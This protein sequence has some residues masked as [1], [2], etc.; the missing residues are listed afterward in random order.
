M[1]PTAVSQVIEQIMNTVF[2]LGFAAVFIK[3]SVELGC[4][5]A[6]IGTTLGAVASAVYLMIVYV[7]T[8]HVK[9][10]NINEQVS[11]RRYTNRQ[12]L[13]KILKY[14]IPIT[15]CIGVT[16]AGNLID[17]ANTTARLIAAGFT[18]Y[19]AQATFGSYA[20][21][22]TLINVP[23]TIISSLAVVVLPA[24]SKAI[25]VKDRDLA[26]RK[27]NFAFKLCFLIAVPA[28]AG[29]SVLS[30]P[31]FSLLYSTKYIAGYK[32]MVYGSVV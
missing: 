11:H 21:Y 10:K 4:V 14:G 28:A 17:T 26:R 5:G 27:M 24:I 16:N 22:I 19:Q 6:T 3:Y 23:T 20:K 31:V 30:G 7:N 12:I 1:K 13:K 18:Q 32:I 15:I 2:S 29:L 8:S 9:P 25:A